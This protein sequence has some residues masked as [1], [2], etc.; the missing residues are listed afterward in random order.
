MSY[1]H[2]QPGTAFQTILEKSVKFVF[3]AKD[4]LNFQTSEVHRPQKI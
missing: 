3:E 2:T 1:C 4:T